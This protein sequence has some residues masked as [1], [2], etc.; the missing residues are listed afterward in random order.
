MS[1]LYENTSMLDKAVDEAMGWINHP[2]RA[3]KPYVAIAEVARKYGISSKVLS[4]LMNIR[5]K[6][7]EKPTITKSKEK[8]MQVRP[9]TVQ[10]SLF[11][12]EFP[13]RQG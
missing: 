6:S 3:L 8:M 7:K 1:L 13:P 4:I 12:E 5:K 10:G 9:T 11:P 2:T